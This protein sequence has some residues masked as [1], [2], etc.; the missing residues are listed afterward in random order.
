M[1]ETK[2]LFIAAH[3]IF[4]HSSSTVCWP[5]WGAQM[6]CWLPRWYFLSLCS[7]MAL[8]CQVLIQ[9]IERLQ[10]MHVICLDSGTWDGTGFSVRG[11][12][13]GSGITKRSRSLMYRLQSPSAVSSLGSNTQPTHF[14]AAS[15]PARTAVWFSSPED[16]PVVQFLCCYCYDE[17]DSWLRGFILVSIYSINYLI[18]VVCFPW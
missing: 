3:F 6:C 13:K 4:R 7:T 10:M 8:Y 9:Y 1:A 2:C 11:S 5:C 16:T 17:F 15:P 18:K 12:Q 14:H